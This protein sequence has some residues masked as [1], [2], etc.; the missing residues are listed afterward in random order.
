MA[1]PSLE[2]ILAIAQQAKRVVD[3]RKKWNDAQKTNASAFHEMDESQKAL[4]V[5]IDKIGE[6]L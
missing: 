2:D 5:M 1:I 3:F 6:D 4:M